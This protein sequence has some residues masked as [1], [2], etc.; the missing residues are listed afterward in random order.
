[1]GTPCLA[2]MTAAAVCVLLA[3]LTAGGDLPRPAALK[4]AEAT[5]GSEVTQD[6]VRFKVSDKVLAHVDDRLFG[7]FMER[8]SW[9]EIGVEGAVISD[10]GDL[11]P[12]VIELLEDMKVPIVRFPGGTDVDYID[13]RDMVDN[14]P[15]RPG[16][17]PVT[18]G[19]TGQQVTNRFGY[20][21]FLRLSERL[22]WQDIIVV[23]MGDALLGRKPVRDAALHAAGLVAYCN[24]PVGQALPEGM[25]DWPSVR[26]ANGHPQPYAVKYVQLGNETWAFRKKMDEMHPG[27]R[28]EVYVECVAEYE[29]AIHAVDSGAVLLMDYDEDAT[30]LLRKRLGNRI[31]Y[32]CSHFYTPWGIH[33]VQRDGV[34]VPMEGLTAEDIW[35]TWVATPWLDRDGQ[36]VLRSDAFAAAQKLGYRVAVTE[37]NWNGGWWGHGTT[38]MALDSDLSRGLGAAGLL[39]GLMRRSDVTEIGTQ[40]MLVGIGWGIAA[41]AVDRNGVSPARMRPSGLVTMMYS[42][43]HGDRLMAMESEGVPCYRQP[44]EMGGIRPTEKVATV[45]A[46]AT[47]SEGAAFLHAINRSFDRPMPVSLDLT[48]LGPVAGSGWMYVLQGRLE[49]EKDVPPEE[50]LAWI[51]QSAVPVVNGV[52]SVELPPRSVTVIEV[53]RARQAGN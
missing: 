51:T 21:E 22:G 38:G 53:P 26:A 28:T 18:T 6:T 8:P 11:Q 30:P 12:R 3:A 19:H 40:S 52:A 36:S 29:R 9:G 31:A 27:R 5:G 35:N 44:F 34:E 50:P 39:H 10:A 7:Q 1:M 49:R 25:P 32:V 33:S 45:D 24:A 17:R 15:G 47:A 41:I 13:W 2:G 4:R 14:V 20:D 23:N 48:A 16:G 46:L 37:W 43:H 42:Q